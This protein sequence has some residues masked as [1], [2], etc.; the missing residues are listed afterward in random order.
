MITING[1]QRRYVDLEAWP[2]IVGAAYLPSS[3]VP[4]GSTPEGLPVGMQVVAPYL[5]DR[6]AIAVGGLLAEACTDLGGGFRVPPAVEGT[7]TVW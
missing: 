4:V 1:Q 7:V 5:H 2:A 6:R 3:A